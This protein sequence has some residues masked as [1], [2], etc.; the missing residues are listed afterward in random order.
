ML[1]KH[2]F[3]GLMALFLIGCGYKPAAWYAKEAI[4]GDVF[5]DVQ[6]SVIDPKNAVLVKDAMN[7]I[8]ITK[9]GNKLV[10]DRSKAQTVVDMKLG[11]VSL[12]QIQYNAEGYVRLYRSK[13][14]VI[15]KYRNKNRSGSFTITGDYDFS[16]GG[17]TTV[18]SDAKRFEAIKNAAS[19]A[20]DEIV[21]RLAVEAYRR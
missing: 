6:I 19:D 18:I 20:M 12:T 16:V 17:D 21:S 15:V 2:L 4:Q 3:V 10:K 5:V 8:I 13:I 1:K 11:T 14:P 7:E 9:F